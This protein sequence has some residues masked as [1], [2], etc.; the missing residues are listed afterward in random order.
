M[1]ISLYSTGSYLQV[2]QLRFQGFFTALWWF[3][4]YF[5]SVLAMFLIGLY[6]GK[7]NIFQ[8]IQQHLPFV[9]KMMWYGLGIGLIFNSFFVYMSIRQ[10]ESPQFAPLL[11]VGSRIIGAPALSL[12]YITGIILLFQKEKWQERLMPL[13]YVGRMALSN[14]II[15]SIFATSI[16]FGYGLGLYG[17]TDPSF[18]LLLTIGI[19]LAQI[20]FSQWW[21]ER[22]QFGPLEWLWRTLSYAKRQPFTVRET[23]KDIAYPS[24]PSIKLQFLRLGFAWIIIGSWIGVLLIW[25][26]RIS[27]SSRVST[28]ELAIRGTPSAQLRIASDLDTSFY[29]IDPISTPDVEPIPY[30]PN[31]AAASGNLW[32]IASD[33]DFEFA[34]NAIEQLSDVQFD[35]RAAGSVGGWAAGDYLASEFSHYGLQP[36]G[37]AGSFFQSFPLTYTPLD[38][39]P[40]FAIEDANGNIQDTYSLHQ[41]FS[42]IISSYAGTGSG[43]GHVVWVNDC[44]REDFSKINVVGNIVF[45]RLGPLQEIGRN[46]IENGAAG[47]LLLTNPFQLP[48]DFVDAYLPSWVPDPLP[49]YRVYPEVAEDLLA[50]SGVSIPDLSI[51]FS[52]FSLQTKVRMQV[53]SSTPPSCPSSICQGR[54]VLGV[55]PGWDPAFND[56]VVI[57]GA[58]YDHL[59]SNPNNII[60][61]GANDNASGISILLEIAR[62]WHEQEYVPRVTTVFAAWDAKELGS[63]GSQYYINHPRYPLQNTAIVLQIDQVG[64]GISPLIIDGKSDLTANFSGAATALGIEAEITNNL[65]GDHTPFINANIPAHL[66]TWFN[67]NE[68]KSNSRLPTDT[69]EYIDQQLLETAGKI[70]ELSLLSIIEG[71]A[72]IDNLLDKRAD[73]TLRNDLTSFLTTSTNKQQNSSKL[74]FDDI[75]TLSPENLEFITDNLSIAGVTANATVTISVEIPN[76]SQGT[77]EDVTTRWIKA[78][79]QVQFRYNNSGWQWD[80]PNLFADLIPEN[81]VLEN[82][83]IISSTRF[84]IMHPAD[85]TES[86][87]GLAQVAAEEYQNNS[88]LLGLPTETDS[89]IQLFSSNESLH[90]NTAL[91]LPRSQNMWV[92]PSVLKLTYSSDISSG[93]R[94][95]SGVAQL[96]L[97]NAGITENAAPW[98]WEGL[99]L[100]LHAEN[101]SVD[102]Q[103]QFVPKLQAALL[104]NNSEFISS[105]ASSWAKVDFLRH[106]LGWQGLGSFISA[107]GQ[108]C[109]SASCQNDDAINA[110]LLE[111]LQMDNVSFHAAWQQN[112][113]TRLLSTQKSLDENLAMRSSSIVQG[114]FTAFLNTVDEKVPNLKS[115][116]ASWLESISQHNIRSF[117]LS[118][119]PITFFED[120]TILASVLMNYQLREANENLG[121]A[122]VS[123]NILFTPNQNGLLWAGPYMEELSG[124]LVSVRYPKGKEILAQDILNNADSIYPQLADQLHITYPEPV[125]INLYENNLTFQNSISLTFPTG[126]QFSYFT[127]NNQSIKLLLFPDSNAENYRPALTSSL[128]RQLLYQVGVD[129]E[130][131]LTG[132]P[133]YFAWPT[134]HGANQMDAAARLHALTRGIKD[135]SLFNLIDFPHLHS[136]S[137]EE[138]DI[139]FPQ[140]WDTIRYLAETYGINA[141]YNLFQAQG[142]GQSIDSA[143]QNNLGISVDSFEAMWQASYSQGH[144]SP[145]WVETALKFDPSQ[146]ENHIA[147]L[148]DPAL[149]G[150]QAGSPGAAIAAAYITTQFEKYGLTTTIQ[151]FPITYREYLEA[152]IFNITLPGDSQHSFLHRQDFL[153]L[154]NAETGIPINGE[155]IWIADEN[156]TDMDLDGKIAVR[157]PCLAIEEEIELAV[158]HGASALILVGDKNRNS[159]LLAKFPISPEIPKFN[160]PVIELT[161]NGFTRL[162]ELTGQS[163]ASIYDTP[164]AILLGVDIE[165]KTSLTTP[166]PSETSNILGLL[167]GSDPYLSQQFIILCAHY[168]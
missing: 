62:N 58:N 82:S 88:Q 73:A 114:D 98:L 134:D 38:R 117:S 33:F 90:A 130:W 5:G 99:P 37:D 27:L 159:D 144:A 42:P 79:S 109:Q 18:G 162:L 12:F 148:T 102:I 75:Q 35:G 138:Y 120:G 85:K 146:V 8:Q 69:K 70:V 31:F 49:T 151:S 66:L 52:P 48:P 119:H 81:N 19:Y 76:T 111:E 71:Q 96:I 72:S 86:L 60:W 147:S 54:N 121:Q 95:S 143:L 135:E 163:K 156:Y 141:L 101:Y 67:D 51:I 11:R 92:G 22:Y 63:L 132:I 113:L 160:I 128:I 89:L 80:G 21:F 104:A 136:L 56:K 137:T 32:S 10:I 45:C 127:A 4:C 145:F 105:N 87:E 125:T 167:P 107:L 164:P 77:S 166:I 40:V 91:T 118:A 61:S 50:G 140:A 131:L 64:A 133:A 154:Q 74:W 158:S 16:F 34:F 94:L 15:H 20:R 57:L 44:N 68:F 165:I 3:P 123:H 7:R 116:Q 43:E 41:D 9:R 93:Q 150:R 39:L 36:A 122:S 2:T 115:E 106:Q 46:A 108:I 83:E 103:T 142:A 129:S 25:Q 84:V 155:L 126:D 59:G 100:V 13:A 6:T 124:N 65:D 53:S 112:W 26:N 17:E 24:E 28:L 47:L 110:V 29:A 153:V 97:A 78:T 1:P 149:A 139:A 168:D 152:P 157:S 23:Y 161:R 14:Y 30:N 55:F